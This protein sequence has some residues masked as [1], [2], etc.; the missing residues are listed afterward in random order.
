MVEKW[1]YDE[2]C[3]K[4]PPTTLLNWIPQGPQPHPYALLRRFYVKTDLSERGVTF[5][6]H[7]KNGSWTG[8]RRLWTP[9]PASWSRGRIQVDAKERHHQA[10]PCIKVEEIK[11][12]STCTWKLKEDSKDAILPA[13]IPLTNLIKAFQQI[14]CLQGAHKSGI[15]IIHCTPFWAQ[16]PASRDTWMSWNIGN[17]LL[18]IILFHRF[19]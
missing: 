17:S 2:I 3:I 12:E 10:P 15:H 9:K 6:H 18:I 14:L 7:W 1:K 8:P 19:H 11:E 5:G 16:T 4:P 13:V